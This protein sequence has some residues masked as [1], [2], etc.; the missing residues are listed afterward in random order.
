MPQASARASSRLRRIAA[1]A[2]PTAI[3]IV[4]LNFCLLQLVPGDAVDVL[5]A[6]AGSATAETMAQLRSS[7]GLDQSFFAQLGQ[8]LWRLA[9]FDLGQSS[10]YHAPVA[11]LILSRL[12][13]TLLLMVV[14]LA[15]AVVVGV[16]CGVLMSIWAGR[17]PDQLLS[18]AAM[19]L[20]AM[21]G[22]W[23]AL[24]IVVI[25]SVQLG[26]FP[27]GGHAT[28]GAD[29]Q[30]LAWWRDRALH[31]T[32]P[33][34]SLS[35]FFVSI[36]ARL[37]RAAMLEVNRQDFVRTATAKGLSPLAIQLRHVLRNALIPV[38][39][40]MGLHLGNLL[41]GSVVIET[42][43]GWPGM[44]SLALEAM[45]ARDYPVLLGVL[46]LGSFVVIAANALVDLLHAWLDPRIQGD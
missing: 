26:W 41:G 24:M 32:L 15:I 28:L 16:A 34:L 14:A 17:W 39:T 29:L 30:G 19:L 23:V 36:Y 25:F 45:L 35:T 1:Q 18:V 9:H 11:E 42:V 27:S 21:P 6:E 4:I 2:L 3:G 8:Y 12:P 33:A 31:L 7:L 5:A 37:T 20:H 38:T 44:G 40:V 46:L 13:G 10:R 43:F 22:F